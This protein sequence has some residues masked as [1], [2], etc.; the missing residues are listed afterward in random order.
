MHTNIPG[1][2]FQEIKAGKG[3]I[4]QPHAWWKQDLKD[5]SLAIQSRDDSLRG[6]RVPHELLFSCQFCQISPSQRSSPW[7]QTAFN[8]DLISQLYVN[9]LSDIS[10]CNSKPPTQMGSRVSPIRP[11]IYGWRISSGPRSKGPAL[12]R[13]KSHSTGNKLFVTTNSFKFMQP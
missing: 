12:L 8:H 13:A 7:R 1:L 4:N 9:T 11:S 3:T 2:C 5:A 10:H 6:Q